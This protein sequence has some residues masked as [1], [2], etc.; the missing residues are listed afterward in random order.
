MAQP[1][2]ILTQVLKHYGP[3]IYSMGLVKQA[4]F[5][6]GATSKSR[7]C[8]KFGKF[9]SIIILILLYLKNYM[10]QPYQILIQTS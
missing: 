9:T 4:K 6:R 1:L 5:I 3:L 10:S 2:P 7:Y 8:P